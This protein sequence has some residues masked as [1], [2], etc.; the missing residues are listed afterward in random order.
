MV[1]FTALISTALMASSLLAPVIAHP[2]V[3]EPDD[4]VKRND[5]WSHAKRSVADCTNSLK[6]RSMMKRAAERRSLLA[7]SLREKR[8]LLSKS[9]L[10]R[11]DF[12]THANITHN[13]NLTDISPNIAPDSLFTGNLNCVLAPEVTQGPYFVTGEYVRNNVKECQEGVDLFLDMQFI[14]VNTCEPVPNIFLDIWHANAT[15]VCMFLRSILFQNATNRLEQIP[16][17]LQM[18]MV[19]PAISLTLTILFFVAWLPPMRMV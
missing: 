4:L 1:Q 3:H 8:G 15:G 17:L 12:A 18:V 13:S 6:G 2:G 5:V 9:M 19:I 7:N 10:H 11:R 14:N 16:V